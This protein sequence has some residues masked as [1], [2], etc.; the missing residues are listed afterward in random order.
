MEIQSRLKSSWKHQVPMD[1]KI[2]HGK[3][4]WDITVVFCDFE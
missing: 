1:R 2:R 3:M 4:T